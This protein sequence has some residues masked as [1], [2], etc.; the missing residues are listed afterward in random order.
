MKIQ[1]MLASLIAVSIAGSAFAAHDQSGTR[2]YTPEA[3]KKLQT[4]TRFMPS[5][6]E[7]KHPACVEQRSQIISCVQADGAD[8]NIAAGNGLSLLSNYAGYDDEEMVQL[9]LDHNAD[10]DVKF[11]HHIRR[12]PLFCVNSGRM[13]HLLC[14][15]GAT[16]DWPELMF[17]THEEHNSALHYAVENNKS[18]EVLAALCEVDLDPNEFNNPKSGAN[19]MGMMISKILYCRDERY[20]KHLGVLH[21]YGG[22]IDQVNSKN[23]KLRTFDGFPSSTKNR[24][25]NV[26]AKISDRREKARES[27]ATA[28]VLAL[29]APPPLHRLITD[30]YGI[31]LLSGPEIDSWGELIE[32]M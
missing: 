1:H 25:R 18:A 3:T 9:L 29:Q 31:P 14:D 10:I 21:W 8:P 22:S 4:L 23:P 20:T 26:L 24:L 15:R 13:V 6:G 5:I 27:V 17:T 28:L 11:F 2:K 32:G 30:Y 7:Q 16:T 12:M 19:A